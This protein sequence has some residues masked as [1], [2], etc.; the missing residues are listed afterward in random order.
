MHFCGHELLLVS[1]LLGMVPLELA[2]LRRAMHR[3][4]LGR[5]YGMGWRRARQLHPVASRLVQIEEWYGR[6]RLPAAG[7]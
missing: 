2:M 7:R 5:A 3:V 6:K 1:G 4:R